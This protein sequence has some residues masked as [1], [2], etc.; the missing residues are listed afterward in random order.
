VRDDPHGWVG[1]HGRRGGVEL[2][3]ERVEDR[4]ALAGSGARI[5]SW[6]RQSSVR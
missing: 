1:E 2:A 4:D 6:T 5:A 3:V